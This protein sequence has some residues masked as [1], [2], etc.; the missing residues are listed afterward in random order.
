MADLTVLTSKKETFSMVTA[1]SLC[2]GTPVVG[3]K[4]GG[5]EQIAIPEYSM[6]A[7]YGAID[8]LS[9]CTLQL[10]EVPREKAVVAKNAHIKYAA[11]K[12]VNHY[13]ACYEQLTEYGKGKDINETN[14]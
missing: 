8:Q 11:E 2:C 3:F 14:R 10:L 6:F 5:P 4:A 13:I 9:Q 7:E 1:E 12:M